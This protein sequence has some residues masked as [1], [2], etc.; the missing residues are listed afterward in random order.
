MPAD[1]S[2]HAVKLSA[3][4]AAL[5]FSSVAVFR[6]V[7]TPRNSPDEVR[8]VPGTDLGVAIHAAP[9]N[10]WPWL[11]LLGNVLLLWPLGALLPLR[12]PRFAGLTRIVTAAVATTCL[13]ELFQFTAVPGRVVSTDDVLLNTAGALLGAVCSRKWWDDFRELAR[14][15][16]VL[17]L[18]GLL[19]APTGRHALKPR[20]ARFHGT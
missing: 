2:A 12:V 20:Y 10:I 19:S 16:W 18:A 11:Q 14:P 4:D 9:G 6:L 13:I 3:V 15:R 5:A 8:L 1:R 7:S 17:L